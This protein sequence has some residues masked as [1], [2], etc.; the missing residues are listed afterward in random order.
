MYCEEGRDKFTVRQNVLGHMQQVKHF[1]RHQIKCKPLSIA[2]I[3][4]SISLLM[5]LILTILAIQGGSPSPFDRSL[6]TKVAIN[7][8]S[9][10]SFWLQMLDNRKHIFHYTDF[11][12]TAWSKS[13]RVACK[14]THQSGF[15]QW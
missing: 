15:V 3:L 6:A 5:V 4:L 12:L 11:P 2:F 7:D 9:L 1:C 14:S 8:G 13:S 10:K